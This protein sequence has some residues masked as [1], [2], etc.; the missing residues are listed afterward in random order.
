[1]K[2]R[3]VA[4]S[5]LWCTL[6]SLGAWGRPVPPRDKAGASAPH[7]GRIEL[8]AVP[9]WSRLPR[10]G[11]STAR[12]VYSR[13]RRDLDSEVDVAV[14]GPSPRRGLILA[15]RRLAAQLSH[16]LSG[17][18]A[19]MTGTKIVA[20]GVRNPQSV[21]ISYRVVGRRYPEVHRVTLV[22]V[23]GRLLAVGVALFARGPARNAREGSK[24]AFS[25]WRREVQ[26]VQA[27]RDIR[28]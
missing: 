5:A 4:S 22:L 26:R 24:A 21:D 2:L 11:G 28:P 18:G 9:G 13:N 27:G 23:R 14:L 3:V 12:V 19:R 10:S 17:T 25:L 1:M 15:A 8:P 6:W 16:A 20:A 7:A